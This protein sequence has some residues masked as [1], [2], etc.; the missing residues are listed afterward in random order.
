MLS[1]T[2]CGSAKAVVE[3]TDSS[4][5]KMKNA[6]SVEVMSFISACAS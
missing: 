3:V 4:R 1:P 2:L 6:S 5:P